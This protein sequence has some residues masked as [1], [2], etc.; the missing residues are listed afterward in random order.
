MSFQP[1]RIEAAED[2]AQASF[3]Q[4]RSEWLDAFASLENSV[5]EK[6]HGLGLLDGGDNKPFGQRLPYLR[7]APPSPQLSKDKAKALGELADRC[8]ALLPLRAAIVH[9]AMGEGSRGTE[10]V[11]FFHN[12]AGTRRGDLFCVV[13]TQ[14]DFVRSIRELRDLAE[15]VKF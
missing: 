14:E 3:A 11:A 4:S 15:R 9:S 10:P 12:V 2:S 5:C 7:N 8:A 6:P 13:M 1:Q